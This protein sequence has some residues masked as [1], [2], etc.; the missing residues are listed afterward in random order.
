MPQYSAD[1]IIKALLKHGF[2]LVRSKGSHQIFKNQEG[3]M[4]PVP[5]HGKKKS[6]PL[7]TA[8]AIIR[9]SGIARE[10]F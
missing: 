9:Q 5:F 10:E 4:V 2:Q 3:F 1:R 7:G 6:I 8:L